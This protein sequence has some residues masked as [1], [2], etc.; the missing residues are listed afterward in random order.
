MSL[1]V[2]RNCCIIQIVSKGYFTIRYMRNT[3]GIVRVTMS[4]VL[5]RNYLQS[6]RGNRISLY[7]MLYSES[8][9]CVPLLFCVDSSGSIE[10]TVLEKGVEC[11]FV[12]GDVF[13]LLMFFQALVAKSIGFMEMILNPVQVEM[14]PK[15]YVINSMRLNCDLEQIMKE[16]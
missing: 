8:L 9:Y 6:L 10:S 11:F 16:V 2:I 4:L 14:V 5:Q 1:F 7:C 3:G 12:T 15:T 13:C